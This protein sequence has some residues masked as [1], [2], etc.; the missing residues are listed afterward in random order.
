MRNLNLLV[1]CHDLGETLDGRDVYQ[2]TKT[3]CQLLDNLSKITIVSNDQ[4][5]QS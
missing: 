1:S 3:T 5:F 2:T 4:R